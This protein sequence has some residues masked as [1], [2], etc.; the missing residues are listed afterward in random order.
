MAAHGI[1]FGSPEIDLEKLRA[2]K[3]GVVRKLTGGLKLLAKQRKVDVVQG[4][5]RFVGPHVV[6][7]TAGSSKTRIHFDQ[8]IIAAGSEA[9]RLPGLPDDPRIMDSSDALELPEFS[10]RLLI[11]GGGIIG[12][13]MACVY[14][15][16][17]SKV[18]VVELTPQL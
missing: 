7:V 2:W 17:G 9:I 16:L 1:N 6:E 14:E 11:I 3:A 12:L 8:C 18:S 5:A 10:G 4:T 13:E 15:A